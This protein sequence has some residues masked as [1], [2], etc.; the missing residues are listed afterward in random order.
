MTTQEKQTM[1]SRTRA[2]LILVALGVAF[3]FGL[4][5]LHHLSSQADADRRRQASERASQYLH[6]SEQQRRDSQ[7]HMWDRLLPRR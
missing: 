7:D 3:V 1:T 4:L 5:V 2:I 6:E